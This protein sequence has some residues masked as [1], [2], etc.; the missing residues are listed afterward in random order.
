MGEG[1]GTAWLSFGKL[2]QCPHCPA[3]WWLTLPS[4]KSCSCRFSHKALIASFPPCSVPGDLN[5]GLKILDVVIKL[6]RHVSGPLYILLGDSF[7]G[8][9][10]HCFSFL[11][12]HLW[13]RENQ[14]E[15]LLA[16]GVTAL[17]SAGCELLS[18]SRFKRQGRDFLRSVFYFFLILKLWVLATPIQSSVSV[19]EMFSRCLL[20]SQVGLCFCCQRIPMPPCRSVLRSWGFCCFSWV[21]IFKLLCIAVK[22]I[23]VLISFVNR[24]LW[25]TRDI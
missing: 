1:R 4:E 13:W 2:G 15:D 10:A 6:S 17:T 19:A 23:L 9:L 12:S 24:I 3:L 8:P 11:R 5:T 22:L 18:H 16:V 14:S 25:A 21:S 20:W 7:L